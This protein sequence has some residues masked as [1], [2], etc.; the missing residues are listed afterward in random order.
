MVGVGGDGERNLTRISFSLHITGVQPQ[1]QK[2]FNIALD[3]N[4]NEVSSFSSFYTK[5]LCQR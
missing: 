2:V 5:S 1:E 3:S 4:Q